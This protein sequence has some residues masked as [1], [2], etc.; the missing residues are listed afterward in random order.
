MLYNNA[1]L[2]FMFGLFLVFAVGETITGFHV[3]NEDQQQAHQPQ[4]SY[5]QYL[6][7]GHCREAL[8]ENWESEYLEMG[9]FVLLTAFFIQRGAAESK[10]PAEEEGPSE[11]PGGAAE[12]SRA[13]WPVRRGGWVAKLYEHSLSASLLVLFLACFFLHAHWGAAAYN[14]EQALQGHPTHYGALG[15]IATANFWYQSFQNWQ[16]EFLGV[17]T[18]TLLSIWLRERNSP[19]SKPV[20]A[21]ADK[22]GAQ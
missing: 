20:E 11:P 8:L 14:H 10:P 5:P 22:T 1:L 2:L 19:E 15:Y 12:V 18:L 13:P 9:M 3:Y 6:M 16:S 4:I 17:A 7:T 21:P